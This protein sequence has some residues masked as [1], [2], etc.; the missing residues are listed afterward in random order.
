M[1]SNKHFSTAASHKVTFYIPSLRT[2]S[3][4]RNDDQSGVSPYCR[5]LFG[6]RRENRW[7]PLFEQRRSLPRQYG[8]A[9]EQVSERTTN[10][11]AFDNKKVVVSFSSLFSACG[12]SRS[13]QLCI[14][15]STAQRIS[16][17][18]NN[19]DI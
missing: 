14:E 7:K 15:F 16:L 2:R 6:T 5:K 13:I 12:V 8:A 9:S 11:R 1:T 3:L 17:I 10:N 18:I 4:F 19:R